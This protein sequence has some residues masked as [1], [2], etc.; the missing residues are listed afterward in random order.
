MKRNSLIYRHLQV[1]ENFYRHLII[2]RNLIIRHLKQSLLFGTIFAY[3]KGRAQQGD[4]L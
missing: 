1:L 4:N 3:H 2:L